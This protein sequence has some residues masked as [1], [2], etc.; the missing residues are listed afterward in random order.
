[1]GLE[2]ATYTF[3]V[4]FEEKLELRKRQTSNTAT[5]GW[6]DAVPLDLAHSAIY[7]LADIRAFKSGLRPDL[8]Q[9]LEAGGPGAGGDTVPEKGP[10]VGAALWSYSSTDGGRKSSLAEL[11][12][13]LDTFGLVITTDDV[14]RA[15]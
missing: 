6:S 2:P 11:K 1:M 3:Y 13:A 15:A 10:A 4:N 7:Y 8:R 5:T 14:T 9:L 12:D